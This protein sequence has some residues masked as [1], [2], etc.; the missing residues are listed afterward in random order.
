MCIRDRRHLVR[1][2]IGI[3]PFLRI[4][5]NF[6]HTTAVIPGVRSIPLDVYKRQ[7][8]RRVCVHLYHGLPVLPRFRFVWR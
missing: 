8:F 7:S 1:G 6:E 3:G 5:R 4:Q 2:E